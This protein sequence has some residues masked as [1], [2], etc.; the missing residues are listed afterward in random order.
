MGGIGGIAE[1]LVVVTLLFGGTW[2]NRDSNP[3]R[4]KRLGRL[5]RV[6]DD[7]RV[8]EADALTEEDLMAR[9]S[10]PSLLVPRVPKWRTRTIGAWRA[11]IEVTT[12]NTKRYKGYFF[13][14]L[15]GRFL[16]LVVCW[17]WDLVYWV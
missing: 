2:I 9:T 15:L 10:S 16:F 5:T 14:R 12:P 17:Y 13:S 8:G 3:E 7:A 6:S 4:K 11:R 1:P